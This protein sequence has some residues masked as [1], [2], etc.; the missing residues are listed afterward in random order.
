[1]EVMVNDQPAG[2]VDHLFIDG[3][4]GRN[5]IHGVWSEHD[6]PF[7]AS[8]LKPGTNTIKLIVPA[9]SLQSGVMY[10]YLRLEME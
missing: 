1:M 5:G 4:I 9:G 8:L 3:A 7:D 2:T 6:V 10:D